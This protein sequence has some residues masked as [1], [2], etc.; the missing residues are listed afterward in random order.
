MSSVVNTSISILGPGSLGSALAIALRLAGYSV[1]EIIH[2]ASPKSYR[3]ARALAKRVGAE[4][5]SLVNASLDA[6]ILWLCVPDR[7]IAKVAR[8]LA[9]KKKS[10]KGT[11]V[12][13]SSGALPSDELSP[14]R[15]LGATV[16]SLHPLMTFVPGIDQSFVGVPFAV[17]G[18]AS[19]V[20]QSRAIVYAL[21]GE[22]FAIPKSGKAAYHAWASFT[23]PLL[24]SLLVTSEQ[25]ARLAG[26]PS[27]QAR[28]RMLPIVLQTI[29]NY[30]NQ[31]SAN[32]F[33][34]PILRGDTATIERHLHVLKRSP[35]AREVYRALANAA[36][37]TLPAANRKAQ[38]ALLRRMGSKSSF[39]EPNA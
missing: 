30:V 14:L 18:D 34:G 28:R 7:S 3:K 38:R 21:G 37:D 32:A 8:E 13:H 12:L 24:L 33:S 6:D 29:E 15:K 22:I 39:R 19:A 11:V 23:S 25:V 35:Q 4:S 26:I 5:R 17:E 2:H 27:K 20:R 16:A 1:E 10:W 31:G 9:E 36:L